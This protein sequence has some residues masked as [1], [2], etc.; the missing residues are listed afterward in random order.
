MIKNKTTIIAACFGSSL[1]VSLLRSIQFSEAFTIGNFL[2][3]FI[4]TS[5]IVFLIVFLFNKIIK[6]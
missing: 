1:A 3:T 6:R 5:F 4:S 2:F